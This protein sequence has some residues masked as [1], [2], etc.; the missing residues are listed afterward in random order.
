MSICSRITY[1]FSTLSSIL[2]SVSKPR[3]LN[4]F[5]KL[6]EFISIL[7][8]KAA[9]N[10][11]FKDEENRVRY[12]QVIITHK[13]VFIIQTCSCY[14]WS[15]DRKFKFRNHNCPNYSVVNITVYNVIDFIIDNPN[16]LKSTLIH[17]YTTE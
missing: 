15:E 10:Y 11:E 1:L 14:C 16:L 5:L 4:Q 17:Y 9:P 12:A 6:V 3:V 8:V 13:C 7:K 2:P